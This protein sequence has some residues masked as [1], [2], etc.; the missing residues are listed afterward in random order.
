M[1][2]PK[3]P[4]GHFFIKRMISGTFLE[5]K[6]TLAQVLASRMRLKQLSLQMQDAGSRD[7]LDCH[8]RFH[9]IL[10]TV[11]QFKSNEGKWPVSLF[12]LVQ[13]DS[14]SWTEIGFIDSEGFSYAPR[15]LSS[16]ENPNM[17]QR[18]MWLSAPDGKYVLEGFL[19]GEINVRVVQTQNGK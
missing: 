16:L 17:E 18:I 13:R 1:N 15:L 7:F 12:Q 14:L 9:K 3:L 8:Y 4:T 11:I 5:I 10:Q 2:H 6:P 19:N